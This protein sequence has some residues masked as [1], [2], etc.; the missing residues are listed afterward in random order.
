MAPYQ[1]LSAASSEEDSSDTP[2]KRPAV[3]QTE[4]RHQLL[5]ANDVPSW[6]AHNTYL[7]TGYRPVSGSV[8]LCVDSLRYIHNETV[9]IYSHLIPAAMAV[10]SNFFL[11]V[12]FQH[13]YSTAPLLDRLAVHIF[14]TS[15]II[16]FTI[17]SIYHTLNCHSET[18]S[19]LW[20]RWDYAAIIVQ[21]IGSFVSGIYVTFY[22]N[23]GLQIVYWAMV[24]PP[25][26]HPD[27]FY[28]YHS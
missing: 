22:C 1:R 28:Y 18:Y 8:E 9:N 6:Y 2:R 26:A 14:L 5:S 15:S 16:C 13:R 27:D 21:T 20:A 11:H 10:A 24:N 3:K 12:Y 17:S 23:P 4:A 25:S 19:D 7:L